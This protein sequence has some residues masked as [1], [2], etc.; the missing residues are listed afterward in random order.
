VEVSEEGSFK[1]PG[2]RQD[3]L[4][5][6][7][8]EVS[9]THFCKMLMAPGL[10]VLPIL[11]AFRPFSEPVQRKSLSKLPLATTRASSSRMSMEKPSSIRVSQHFP[12]LISCRLATF[13]SSRRSL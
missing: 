7:H 11:D 6:F 12:L 8:E 10:E 1:R 3:T 2:G 13:S 5:H 4:G 9:P